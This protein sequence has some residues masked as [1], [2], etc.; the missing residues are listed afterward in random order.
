VNA[1]LGA[2]S[3]RR[4]RALKRVFARPLAAI[5][6]VSARSEED[7]A[8][9][10]EIGV[11][12]ARVSVE[13]DMKLDRP[14]ADE[15]AFAESARGLARGRPTWIA[16]SV[17]D[18]ELDAV[19]DAHAQ[20]RRSLDAFLILAPRRPESFED[21]ARRLGERRLAFTR[22]SRLSDTPADVL[23]LDS[24][25]ELA[26]AYRLADASFLGGTFGR[27]GGHNVVEP[28]RASLPTLHGPSTSN[29]RTTLEAATGAVRLVETPAKLG[30]A[31]AAL[32]DDPG[33]RARA[34]ETAERLFAQSSGATRRAA[35]RA[36]A[37]SGRTV[38]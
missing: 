18:E 21:A 5:G 4:Y 3:T 15:P 24:I 38:E 13:G 2:A 1:R 14:L 17:A 36:L 22:R 6:H 30:A 11:P 27:R 23:L 37:M 35:E 16:G 10:R 31:V 34:A 9:F 32:L 7:A 33:A 28:L 29:I 12:A 25:G 19:L 26:G 8:R 20:V